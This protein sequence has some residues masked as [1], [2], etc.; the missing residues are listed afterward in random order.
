MDNIISI[1]IQTP[2]KKAKELANRVRTRRLD[3][4]LTQE[5]LAT[6][7]DIPVATYRKFERT[8]EVSLRGLLKI[9]FALNCLGDFNAL[10]TEKQYQTLDQL[11]QEK[12]TTNRKRGRK[13]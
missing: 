10:F 1:N 13:K 12:K 4:D 9:A 8:G 5:G 3:L 11:L 7:A 6:R 2:E